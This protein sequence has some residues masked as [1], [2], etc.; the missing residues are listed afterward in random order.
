[1]S[2]GELPP[3]GATSEPSL[4]PTSS[5][6]QSRTGQRRSRR[7]NVNELTV[8]FNKHPY[9]LFAESSSDIQIGAGRARQMFSLAP[10]TRL[11]RINESGVFV[12]SGVEKKN[13][14][15]FLFQSWN[16]KLPSK[17]HQS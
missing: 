12:Q 13:V 6:A 10:V 17:L 2:R 14:F 1:M 4:C 3:R 9:F 15:Y 8:N 5:A 16:K 11:S 7:I